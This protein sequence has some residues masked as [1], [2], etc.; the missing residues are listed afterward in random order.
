[1][2]GAM[3]EDMAKRFMLSPAVSQLIDGSARW[4][5]STS[6]LGW[7]PED[8]EGL[9]WD[10]LHGNGGR[11]HDGMLKGGSWYPLVKSKKSSSEIELSKGART[12]GVE[13]E[14]WG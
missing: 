6:A 9:A 5:G 2:L 8:D 13:R 12:R 4:L 11:L 7:L 1:M 10:E 3:P 14:V